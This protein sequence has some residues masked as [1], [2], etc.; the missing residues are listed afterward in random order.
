M[1]ITLYEIQCFTGH[2]TLRTASF[3]LIGANCGQLPNC[4]GWER[5]R[6]TELRRPT[7][8]ASL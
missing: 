4:C 3:R 6:Q 7:S 8:T 2:E 5:D 1:L